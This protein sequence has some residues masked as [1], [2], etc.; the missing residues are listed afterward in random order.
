MTE[1]VVGYIVKALITLAI[2]V[3][4]SVV[5]PA[6][7][8]WVG[9]TNNTKLLSFIQST[10]KAAE[11]V[12][13][14]GTGAAKKAYVISAIQAKFKNLKI[15]SSELDALIESAVYE[16]SGAIKNAAKAIEETQIKSNT[17]ETAGDTTIVKDP[18]KIISDKKSSTTI[19]Y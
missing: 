15:S 13:G 16:V 18:D 2:G 14:S 7:V 5:I 1:V 6:I 10:V 12:F 3:I 8:K 19:Q 9:N 17:S 4:T 11:Q